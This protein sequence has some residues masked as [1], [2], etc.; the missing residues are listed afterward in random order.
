MLYGPKMTAAR[1][2]HKTSGRTNHVTLKDEAGIAGYER[3]NNTNNYHPNI[4]MIPG[5]K[6]MC[7]HVPAEV[8]STDTCR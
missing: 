3:M 4:A 2:H 1:V 6:Y 7:I 5:A 8:G